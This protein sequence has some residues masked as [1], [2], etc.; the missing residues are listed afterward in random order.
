MEPAFATYFTH[1]QRPFY[2]EKRTIRK[3][4]RDMNRVRV[5]RPRS[6]GFYA[7][8][9]ASPP[10][11]G[12]VEDSANPVA[13]S[14][15]SVSEEPFTVR[16]GEL[17]DA[18]EATLL[19]QW[20]EIDQFG[21]KGTV[22]RNKYIQE[23]PQNTEAGGS[24]KNTAGTPDSKSSSLENPD[25]VRRRGSKIAYDD[26]SSVESIVRVFSEKD[27]E[28]SIFN[29]VAGENPGDPV[30]KSMESG[31]KN[32][33]NGMNA[34]TTERSSQTKRRVRRQQAPKNRSRQG[35]Q[36]EHSVPEHVPSQAEKNAAEEWSSDPRWYFLQVKPGC[37]KSCALSLLNMASNLNH[38]LISNVL[39]PTTE[40][41][42]LTKGGKVVKKQ[43]RMFPGYM[44]VHMILDRQSYN[45]V[46]NVPNVQWFM[47]DPNRDK[48]KDEPFRPPVPVSEEEM[49]HVF[50]KLQQA[51][52]S[53]MEVKTDL[54]PGDLVQVV[55]GSHKDAEGT[56]L[57]VKPD[58]NVLKVNLILL[59]R[60][61]PTELEFS[62]VKL[63][64]SGASVKPKKK[65]GRKPKVKLAATEDD[66]AEQVA[67]SGSLH[68]EE[69]PRILQEHEHE[70]NDT[71]EAGFEEAPIKQA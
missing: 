5:A 19:R 64:K 38:V 28:V 16:G 15:N 37:E 34:R 46:K 47:G 36:Q 45:E 68:S 51:E 32:A 41:M 22:P 21:S 40:T 8:N 50:D 65:R 23:A 63:L 12:N 56:V 35:A 53:D 57:A 49:Q 17:D 43:E 54:R 13:S 67:D 48:K 30:A 42:R 39:V 18:L 27:G 4:G 1:C 71:D 7:F 55:S 33:A 25:S 10:D 61:V 26:S 6:F 11:R 44:L 59:G 20:D 3:C 29:E 66:S 24:A 62:Q 14:S 70:E 69:L 2:G 52:S 58:I 9:S 31:V 60:Y